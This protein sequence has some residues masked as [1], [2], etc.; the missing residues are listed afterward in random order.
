MTT[1]CNKFYLVKSGDGCYDIAAANSV[2]LENFYLYNP[3][4]DGCGA[5]WPTYYVC[6]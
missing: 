3:A 1:S 6:N 5:L 4:V 2:S